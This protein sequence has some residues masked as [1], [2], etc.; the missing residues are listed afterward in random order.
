MGYFDV[1]TPYAHSAPFSTTEEFGILQIE[2][3]KAA[4]KNSF[5]MPRVQFTDDGIKFSHFSCHLNNP[6][7]SLLPFTLAIEGFSRR[8][9]GT[10]SDTRNLVSV[11][12]RALLQENLTRFDL[13][14][15]IAQPLVPNWPSAQV[16]VD[17]SRR[18][19]SIFR[20]VLSPILDE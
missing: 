6:K 5:S 8:S 20:D 15:S 7:R 9:G 16:F 10:L 13:I 17:A 18:Q 12:A 14:R 19:A 3:L 2:G 11:A 4:S 1:T